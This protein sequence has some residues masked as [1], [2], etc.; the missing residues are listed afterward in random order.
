MCESKR[1]VLKFATLWWP[2]SFAIVLTKVTAY[3]NPLKCNA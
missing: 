1:D 3:G 2:K